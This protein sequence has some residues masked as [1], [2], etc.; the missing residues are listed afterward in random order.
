MNFTQSDIP[1]EFTTERLLV[2]RQNM[3][4][5]KELFVAA[6]DSQPELVPFLPWC[7]E[8]YGIGDSQAWIESVKPAWENSTGWA[9]GIRDAKSGEYLGGCGVSKIDEHPVANL[10]YWVK[11]AATGKG[12]ASEATVGLAR[13]A[14]RY[15]HFIRV[16]ILMSTE[17]GPSKTV[18]EKS[19]AVFEG[20][21]RNRLLLHGESHDAFLF[22]LTPDDL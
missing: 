12:Y 15:L 10:G 6:R 11:T 13:Y 14:F 7:H 3:D 2:R 9:F 19:G 21:L 4:D 18:A 20:T 5:M 8:N 16:E 1:L 17:N 22:S